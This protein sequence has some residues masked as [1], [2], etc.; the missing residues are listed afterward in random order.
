MDEDKKVLNMFLDIS[1]LVAKKKVVDITNAF[2]AFYHSEKLANNVGFWHW[3]GENYPN[4]LGNAELV[5]STAISKEDWLN[6]ILQGKGYEWDFMTNERINPLNIFGQYDAGE[7]PTQAGIDIT[8]SSF[9]DGTTKTFQNKA[10]LSSNG[11]DLHNTPVDSIV[12]TNVEKVANANKQGYLAQGFMDKSSIELIRDERFD[13]ALTGS[14]T[15]SYDFNNVAS[16]IG[17]AS[18]FGAVIGIGVEGIE[19]YDSW[20]RGEITD[21]EFLTELGKA[22]GDGG[23]TAGAT[24]AIMIFVQDV[25][26]Y[27]GCSSVIG[28]PIAFVVGKTINKIVAPCFARGRYRE[29]LNEAKYYVSSENIYED[30]VGVL[31][32]SMNSS[33]EFFATMKEHKNCFNKLR[34][35]SRKEDMRLR[36][37]LSSI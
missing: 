33:E 18:L 4:T 21:K 25:I 3:I 9:F 5:R 8:R 7:S 11:L 12:V 19:K 31:K 6:K 36:K 22:G 15:G 14:A 16:T 24:S 32:S 29:I 30:F 20:K 28:I 26:T 23:I 2:N 37:L 13:Q 10:Y 27:M 17:A 34:E 1:K 35:C